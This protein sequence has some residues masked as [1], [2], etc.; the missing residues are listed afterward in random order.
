MDARA[1][2]ARGKGTALASTGRT[3]LRS[4]TMDKQSY[5]RPDG[6]EM[7]WVAPHQFVNRE[8][9]IALGLITR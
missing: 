6:V 5:T 8:I 7:V 1:P 3:G 4:E 9:A 2:R